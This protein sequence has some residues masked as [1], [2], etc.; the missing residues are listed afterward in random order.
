MRSAT[1][2]YSWWR[3]GLGKT[4]VRTMSRGGNGSPVEWWRRVV[5]CLWWR[6]WK[7]GGR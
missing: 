7:R 3:L 6:S 4:H 5:G 2:R 1:I